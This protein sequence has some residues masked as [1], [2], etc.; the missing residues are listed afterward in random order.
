MTEG[1]RLEVKVLL[2]S[3]SQFAYFPLQ[4]IRA[5]AICNVRLLNLNDYS[6]SN[7]FKI[8]LSILPVKGNQRRLTNF[9]LQFL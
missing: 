6:E 1:E 3:V 4:N 7:I 5:A 2:L 9:S 8:T